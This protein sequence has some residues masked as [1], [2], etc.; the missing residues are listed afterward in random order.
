MAPKPTKRRALAKTYRNMQAN[1]QSV[2][3]M[4]GAAAATKPDS[5]GD[6][7]LHRADEQ[8]TQR[9]HVEKERMQAVLENWT[10]TLRAPGEKEKA[11]Y[12]SPIE[13]WRMV[14]EEPKAAYT[15][16]AVEQQ[17]ERTSFAGMRDDIKQ[18]LR[19]F[20]DQAASSDGMWPTMEAM[21]PEL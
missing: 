11:V 19:A 10:R 15:R 21:P 8:I 5:M 3:Q 4:L 2:L 14:H 9:V 20:C 13:L 6:T 18:D 1:E 12:H 16:F 17:Q 7:K